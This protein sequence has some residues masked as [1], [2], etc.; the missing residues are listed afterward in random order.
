VKLA[1]AHNPNRLSASRISKGPIATLKA[2]KTLP[3]KGGAFIGLAAMATMA[4]N[5]PEVVWH[6]LATSTQ[7]LAL[8]EAA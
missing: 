7:K 3:I 5:V 2:L 6:F 4:N 8:A 1:K